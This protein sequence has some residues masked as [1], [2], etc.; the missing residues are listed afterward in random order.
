[1]EIFTA[2]EVNDLIVDGNHKT[3]NVKLVDPL[4]R[5][6]LNVKYPGILR[7]CTQIVFAVAYMTSI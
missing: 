3:S 2:T 5:Q 4:A 6:F 1:M 7:E